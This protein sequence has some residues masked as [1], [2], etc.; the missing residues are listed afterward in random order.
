MQMHEVTT[1]EE[2]KD[3]VKYNYY[4]WGYTTEEV[5]ANNNIIKKRFNYYV[6]DWVENYIYYADGSIKGEDWYSDGTHATVI[7]DID[8]NI[9]KTTF[10]ANG[11]VKEYTK[12]DKIGNYKTYNQDNNLIASNVV[13]SPTHSREEQYYDNGKLAYFKETNGDY[14]E[15]EHYN[16]AGKIY[17][18]NI[19]NENEESVTHYAYD[20][21]NNFV[22]SESYDRKTGGRKY[23]EFRGGQ[24]F[25][26]DTLNDKVVS[27]RIVEHGN[28]LSENT[29]EYY[30][31][32]RIKNLTIEEYNENLYRKKVYEYNPEGNSK[33]ND[34]YYVNDK[35]VLHVTEPG[36]Y[37][38]IME[39]D[40][41]SISFSRSDG[42]IFLTIDK[43]GN[44]IY[45]DRNEYQKFSSEMYLGKDGTYYTNITTNGETIKVYGTYTLDENGYIHCKTN[46]NDTYEYNSIGQLIKKEVNGVVYEYDLKNSSVITNKNGKT[47]YALANHIEFDEET[48]E[49]IMKNLMSL[50]DDYPTLINNDCSN[51]EDII[52]TFPDKYSS[53]NLTSINSSV[54]TELTN[55]NELKES[56]NYSLL[57]YSTCDKNLEEKTHALI[58]SLFDESETSLAR[59]FKHEIFDHIHDIDNDRIMEYKKDTNFLELFQNL[60][61]VNSRVDDNG[62]T[63]YS[64]LKG[65]IVGVV[66]VNPKITY[67][68][69][70]F[71]VKVT[72]E[73]LL[74]LIDSKGNAIDIFGEY[75]VGNGQYGGNQ[76]DFQK[77]NVLLHDENILR[78][79]DKYFDLGSTEEIVDFFNK[80]DQ[81]ACG[82]TALTNLVFKEFEGKEDAF[83]KTFGFP[84][85]NFTNS[86]DGAKVD[87][88]YEPIIL[89]LY[90]Y[91]NGKDGGVATTRLYGEGVYNEIYYKMYNYLHDEYGIF[92]KKYNDYI[93]NTGLFGDYGYSLYYMNGDLKYHDG[94]SHAMVKT[95]ELPDGRWLVSTYGEKMICET[96]KPTNEVIHNVD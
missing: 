53:S 39:S 93:A 96:H 52:S 36:T 7:S 81:T 9:Q 29:Y 91:I 38:D 5:D 31:N 70:E 48:Y 22:Q 20:E 49:S 60:I 10:D 88:N 30:E 11:V 58:D 16:E 3:G 84:M 61:P 21:N 43:D 8:G 15:S 59:V 24:L 83:Y 14:F 25:E 18:K 41:E 74:K 13:Y 78:V 57:A 62:N 46:N 90:C 69:E 26:D 67:G 94:G 63:W 40:G 54:Q 19:H 55:I 76:R 85:Y 28:V 34:Y 66:G 27:S 47:T 95:G 42:R 51:C 37:T 32:G 12:G 44:R 92:D 45:K 1:G 73:G 17:Q 71:S 80:V 35:Q 77:A 72:E 64:N 75:N 2:I 6:N 50:Y 65:N 56:I 82:Y 87:F 89:D 33:Y 68:N 4:E 23:V 86:K 79:L